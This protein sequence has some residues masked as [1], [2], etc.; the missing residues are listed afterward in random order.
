MEFY[1][2]LIIILDFIL[3]KHIYVKIS[4]GRQ[5]TSLSRSENENILVYKLIVFFNY[6]FVA[7]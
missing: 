4:E 1:L 3:F 5:L 2:R 6:Y 7:A